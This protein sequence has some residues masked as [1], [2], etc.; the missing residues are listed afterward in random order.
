MGYLHI[1]NLYKNQQILQFKRVYALEKVHGTSAHIRWSQPQDNTQHTTLGFFSGGASHEAFVSLFDQA[2]LQIAFKEKFGDEPTNVII[3]GEAYGGKL[4]GMSRTY[5]NQLRFVAFDVNI[6]GKWLQVEQAARLVE[7]LGLR[8]VDYEQIDATL[9][10]IDRCR[11]LPSTEAA[12]NGVEDADKT[13]REGVVLRPVF[14]VTLNNG[15]RL[16]AKHKREEFRETGSLKTI[17]PTKVE[18]KLRNEAIADDW[19]TARRFEHV[20]DQL[21]RERDDKQVQM[22]DILALLNLMVEDIRREGAGEIEITDEKAFSKAVGAKIVKFVK[23][24][25]QER[26]KD[27]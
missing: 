5:G 3:Y 25:V 7:S 9:S 20:V 23:A 14:E 2:A 19:C 27:V 26:L 17:D 24:A 8:F 15:E 6:D 18:A 12:R 4:M 16:I 13:I 10:E 1:D 11:D 22:P 21:I